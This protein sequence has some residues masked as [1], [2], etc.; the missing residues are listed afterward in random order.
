[1]K[2]KVYDTIILGSGP[3][4]LTAAIY[5]SRSNLKSLV[6]DGKQMGGQLMLTTDVEDFPGFP[7]IVQGPDLIMKMREQAERL[8]AEF[9]GDDVTKVDLKTNPFKVF[10]SSAN[11]ETKTLIISTGANAKWLG[12]PSEKKLIGKGVS[13][14]AVCDAPFF[15][16]KKVAVVGGGDAAMKEALFLSKFASEVTVLHRRDTLRAFQVLQE[17]AFAT[18]NMK[19]IW[20]SEVIEVLG[21]QRVEGVNIKN[22]RSGKTEKLAID[23]L[24]IAIGHTPNTNFLKGQIETDEKGYIA[25]EDQSKTSVPGVFA[26][27]DVHDYRYQQAVT[28]AG[29]GCVAAID[30]EEYLEEEKA[31]EKAQKARS[32][33]E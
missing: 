22:N 15:K 33:T 31:K 17:R 7:E 25:L 18:K 3:A 27:G 19:F 16:N 2:S 12:L 24:F 8:G 10:T 9:T 4:G 14:C 6:V 29:A 13:S 20:N 30:A 23:G 28:A 11:F 26:S 1:M 5:A 32:L 21:D